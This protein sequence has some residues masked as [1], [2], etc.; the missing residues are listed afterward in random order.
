MVNSLLASAT[1]RHRKSATKTTSSNPVLERYKDSLKKTLGILG[2]CCH[3]DHSR[4][5]T[6][7]THQDTCG[8][9]IQ[10]AVYSFGDTR[11]AN[12]T[13]KRRRGKDRDAAAPNLDAT[14][15]CSRCSR[16]CQSRIEL[17]SHVRA[18]SRGGK[19]KEREERGQGEGK[20]QEAARKRRISSPLWRRTEK[21]SAFSA[22]PSSPS[23]FAGTA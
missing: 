4:W 21:A 8:H 15:I 10:Q 6:L 23:V 16:V 12:M 5:S 9:T 2:A 11:K 19:E 22:L 14:F 1:E 18:C 7:A 13:E 3:S 20:E 17:T